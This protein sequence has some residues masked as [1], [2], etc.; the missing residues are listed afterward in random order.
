MCDI[1]EID[2]KGKEMNIRLVIANDFP[3]GDFD[4][5]D[6][7]DV[8][9]D[10]LIENY[11]TENIENKSN[12]EAVGFVVD[13][14]TVPEGLSHKLILNICNGKAFVEWFDAQVE[15]GNDYYQNWIF[16]EKD[17]KYQPFDFEKMMNN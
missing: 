15:F 1:N 10:L 5:D 12:L 2:N 4:N 6:D 14:F 7:D 16:I 3:K 9:S 8:D 11:V 17:G 13:D